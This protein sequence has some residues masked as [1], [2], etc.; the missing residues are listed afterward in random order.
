MELVRL[1]ALSANVRLSFDGVVVEISLD[2]EAVGQ[3]GVVVDERDLN[4]M[5][6][7]VNR[8]G[9]NLDRS[10]DSATAANPCSTASS[11]RVSWLSAIAW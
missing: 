7:G 4:G 2:V 8:G 10:P 11:L 1:P 3:Q 6:Q 5:F 9:V